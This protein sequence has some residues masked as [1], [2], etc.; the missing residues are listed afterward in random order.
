MLIISKYKDYYDYLSGIYGSDPNLVLDRRV[1]QNYELFNDEK[2]TFII[3]GL[4]Y[5]GFYVREQNKVIYGKDL[6]ALGRERKRYQFSWDN[7]RTPSVEIEISG[8]TRFRYGNY[9]NVATEP[10]PDKDGFNEKEKCPILYRY[11]SNNFYH[12]PMLSKYNF[13]SYISAEEMYRLL[14]E[15]LS[16]ERTKLETHIDSRTDVQKLQSKGFDK[17][18]SFR[19][20]IK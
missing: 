15:Y 9:V 7:D 20:N 8:T 3:C 10:Y 1:F 17:K 6:L 14:T 5:E 11:L 18:E 12:F 2:L 16:N 13:G 4:V 19:P